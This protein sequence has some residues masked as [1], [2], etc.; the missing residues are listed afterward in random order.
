MVHSPL[1]GGTPAVGVEAPTGRLNAVVPARMS[2]DL[3]MKLSRSVS[4]P[5]ESELGAVGGMVIR[6]R[7]ASAVNGWGSYAFRKFAPARGGAI[8]TPIRLSPW[9]LLHF[10][11]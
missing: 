10:E 1:P 11:A 5:A 4:C 8:S 7:L 2:F 9:H 3:R 6:I